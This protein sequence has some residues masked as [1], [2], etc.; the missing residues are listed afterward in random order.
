MLLI[1]GV[2]SEINFSLALS[3][4]DLASETNVSTYSYFTSNPPKIK[5]PYIIEIY[6]KTI[7]INTY[8]EKIE[9]YFSNQIKNVR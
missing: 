9:K 5:M 1:N 7:Y 4:P 3:L 2:N 6:Q 8:W